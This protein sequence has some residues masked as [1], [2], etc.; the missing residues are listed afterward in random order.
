MLSSD[1]GGNPGDF[2]GTQGFRVTPV[3]K[4]CYLGVVKVSGNI[5]MFLDSDF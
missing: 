4:H 1:I 2:R 5:F 3:E